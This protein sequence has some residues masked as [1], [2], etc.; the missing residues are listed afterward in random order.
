M[1]VVL[2]RIYS[3]D[4]PK[5]SRAARI[6]RPASIAQMVSSSFSI[7]SIILVLDFTER[8]LSGSDMT[9][10][11]P[12]ER[13][14]R[15]AGTE[16]KLGDLTG[17]TQRAI[18]KAKQKGRP[19]AEMALKIAYALNGAVSFGELRPDL[20]SLNAPHHSLRTVRTSVPPPAR[21]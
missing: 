21:G 20:R 17:Y 11:S 18:N 15:I 13:A 3:A 7:V 5:A 8:M 12:M 2:R 14:I 4:Q 10:L 19:S 9:D 6:F 1:K 16:Q